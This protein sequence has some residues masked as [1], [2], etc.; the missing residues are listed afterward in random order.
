MKDFPA[1]R[2]ES[3]L[4]AAGDC[5]YLLASG[6]DRPN[7]IATITR[8][9]DGLDLYVVSMSF[10]LRLPPPV[11]LEEPGIGYSLE[12]IARGQKSDLEQFHNKVHDGTMQTHL[13]P[14]ESASPPVQWPTAVMFHLAIHTPDRPGITARVSDIIGE[15]RTAPSPQRNGSFI[16]LFAT[17]QNADGPQGATPY[18]SLRAN[19]ATPHAK[20][21]EAIRQDLADYARQE[22]MEQELWTTDL[23][24]GI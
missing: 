13:P 10:G 12:L 9:L 23:D 6:P 1:D 14:L 15:T 8:Q 3:T 2:F 17:T 16:H 7:L 5:L 19:I 24:P 22:A 20:V 4:P 18:F 21:Q 11:G